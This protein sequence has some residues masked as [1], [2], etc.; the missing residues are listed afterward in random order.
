MRQPSLLGLI[1]SE[2][3]RKQPHTEGN[4]FA[5]PRHFQPIS[6]MFR[7]V[8]A[9]AQKVLAGSGAAMEYR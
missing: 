6:G 4:A 8:S 3:M 2:S 5:L 1:L 7:L 9:V